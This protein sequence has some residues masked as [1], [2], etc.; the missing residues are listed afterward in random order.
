MALAPAQ[1]NKEQLHY[2]V[3]C[4]LSSETMETKTETTLTEAGY[5][6]WTFPKCSEAVVTEFPLRSMLSLIIA[7]KCVYPAIRKYC[8][9]C[10]HNMFL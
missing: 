4:Y 7:P 3:G 5:K 2:I 9:V 1:V 6:I 10:S 8:Q